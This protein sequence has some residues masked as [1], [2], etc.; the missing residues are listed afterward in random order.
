[1][2]KSKLY[3][4]ILGF[5]GCTTVF[6]SPAFAG[7]YDGLMRALGKSNPVPTTRPKHFDNNY[8]AQ[9]FDPPGMHG[10]SVNTPI[11]K[12][13]PSTSIRGNFNYQADPISNTFNKAGQRY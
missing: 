1:M 6:S 10:P 7:R 3:F 2:N 9:G 8:N 11:P 4:L 12:P 13:E 5:M